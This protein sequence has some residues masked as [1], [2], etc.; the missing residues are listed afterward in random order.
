MGFFKLIR[1][2]GSIGLAP[3]TGGMSLFGASEDT[4]SK[5][6][7]VGGLTGAQSD[8]EKKLLKKQEEMAKE[9]AKQ[10]RRNEQARLNS[11]GQSMLAFN[12]RNQVM[13]QMFGPEAAF[14]PD[15]FAKMAADPNAAERSANWGKGTEEERIYQAQAK[16]AEQRRQAMIRQNMQQPGPAAAP[17]QQRTPQA[18][19]RRG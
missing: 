19:R 4:R 10:R 17:L 6:P 15:Q 11:I 2:V 1:D 9:A 7:L 14:T 12:P 13:A 16:Q 3:L 5:I 18:S 8:A